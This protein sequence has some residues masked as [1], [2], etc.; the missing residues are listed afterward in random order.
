MFLQFHFKKLALRDIIDK[1]Y[2]TIDISLGIKNGS[3]DQLQ[4]FL[5][6]VDI[7]FDDVIGSLSGPDAGKRRAA[8][9]ACR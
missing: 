7:F 5:H 9:R 8:D 2:D 4:V 6:A 1:G 3:F